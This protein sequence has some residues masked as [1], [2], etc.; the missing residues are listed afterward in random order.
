M[1]A[2]QYFTAIEEA[3]EEAEVDGIEKN[4]MKQVLA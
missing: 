2:I 4:D 3:K 1:N